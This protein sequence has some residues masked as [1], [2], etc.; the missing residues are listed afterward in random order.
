MDGWPTII[1]QDGE[2]SDS[3]EHVYSSGMDNPSISPER[4]HCQTYRHRSLDPLGISHFPATPEL[5]SEQAYRRGSLDSSD[6][7]RLTVTP[8]L[9]SGQAYRRGSLDSPDMSHLT[10]TPEL[11]S[12]QTSGPDTPGNASF[13]PSEILPPTRFGEPSD[14]DPRAVDS[15]HIVT[16]DTLHVTEIE[17]P[18][19]EVDE[20][21]KTDLAKPEHGEVKLTE[22]MPEATLDLASIQ[23]EGHDH[24]KHAG[25]GEVSG[26]LQ[27]VNIGRDLLPIRE[28]DPTSLSPTVSDDLDQGPSNRKGKSRALNY[29]TFSELESQGMEQTVPPLP[30]DPS[31]TAGMSE[32]HENESLCDLEDHS[33]QK[34]PP[35]DATNDTP[36]DAESKS[37]QH[38]YQSFCDIEQPGK[39]QIG[40][41]SAPLVTDPRPLSAESQQGEAPPLPPRPTT[42][43]EMTPRASEQSVNGRTSHRVG[44]IRSWLG[45]VSRS[46]RSPATSDKSRRPTSSQSRARFWINRFHHQGESLTSVQ[47]EGQELVQMDREAAASAKKRGRSLWATIR[48]G[49]KDAKARRA[50]RAH[51]NGSADSLNDCHESFMANFIM[52]VALCCVCIRHICP[53][54]REP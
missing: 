27:G 24:G 51:M 47:L 1:R 21:E 25:A 4:P 19:V 2:A 34:V 40:P 18:E 6:I 11:S 20:T 15:A 29:P 26:E 7:S 30:S 8:E 5:L 16:G 36:G 31:N 42:P 23:I 32:K 41:P 53:P 22:V 13:N 54:K 28:E 12:G 37:T 44:R 10:A 9:L 33:K 50:A 3:D 17:L 14:Q 49:R 48:M 43:Q 45:G 39:E 35:Q 52:T 38:E 46:S